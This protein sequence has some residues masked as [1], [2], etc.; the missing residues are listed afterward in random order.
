MKESESYADDFG[1]D[2]CREEDETESGHDGPGNEARLNPALVSAGPGLDVPDL[3]DGANPVSAALSRPNVTP[4]LADPRSPALDS[5]GVDDA[6]PG[7]QTQEIDQCPRGGDLAGVS[8]ETTVEAPRVPDETVDD[9]SSGYSADGAFGEEDDPGAPSVDDELEVP[10]SPLEEVLT[11]A[12][13][14]LPQGDPLLGPESVVVAVEAIGE[15]ASSSIEG[16]MSDF[17]DAPAENLEDTTEVVAATKAAEWA[18]Q[19]ASGEE[20]AAAVPAEE[21]SQAGSR[22]VATEDEGALGSTSAHTGESSPTE[23]YPSDID[24][25][26]AVDYGED[27]ENSDVDASSAATATVSATNSYSD[28]EPRES[29]LK[30]NPIVLGNGAKTDEAL[31]G[32]T[33]VGNR[34]SSTLNN[35]GKVDSDEVREKGGPESGR[36]QDSSAH[37]V[38]EIQP[39]SREKENSAESQGFHAHPA[40]PT[41][42]SEGN[43]S[44]VNEGS[45]I[46][47]KE[48][49]GQSSRAVVTEPTTSAHLT[50]QQESEA[51]S[52]PVMEEGEMGVRLGKGE[53]VSAA[54]AGEINPTEDELCLKRRKSSA[55]DSEQDF[56]QDFE[57]DFEE[58][59]PSGPPQERQDGHGVD[60][61]V[62]VDEEHSVAMGGGGEVN[63]ASGQGSAR[64]EGANGNMDEKLPPQ[65]A[66]KTSETPGAEEVRRV[67]RPL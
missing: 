59:V 8:P 50:N 32:T 61:E 34:D 36:E 42:L 66:A 17:D 45:E 20:R 29:Q 63:G 35:N 52:A 28:P 41:T 1:E 49:E 2:G 58:D 27:V 38:P 53:H 18:A 7:N 48:A 44:A 51:V 46:D 23:E 22:S 15:E 57:D 37:F 6:A 40:D 24:D 47:T 55:E 19:P 56:E 62:E 13:G 12:N 21:S 4:K 65:F 10:E 64:G 14:L 5:I 11:D 67:K 33:P 25:S 16:Y 54:L 3:G 39:T 26:S 9:E 31:G 60:G 30:S 43:A